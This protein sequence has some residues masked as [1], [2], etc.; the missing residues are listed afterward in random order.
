MRLG[1]MDLQGTSKHLY[2]ASGFGAVRTFVNAVSKV[3]DVF[4]S[5]G[6]GYDSS[7]TY[8]F[9]GRGTFYNTATDLAWSMPGMPVAAVYTAISIDQSG[10][11]LSDQTRKHR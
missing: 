8:G 5:W 4:N 6:Y 2:D 11:L 7:G 1:A 3:H 9:I 10:V